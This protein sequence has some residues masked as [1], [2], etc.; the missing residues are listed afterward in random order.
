M[1]VTSK[2][3]S[4]DVDLMVGTLQWN[5]RNLIGRHAQSACKK[6]Q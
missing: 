5:S 4:N 2:T 1:M 3:L 6:Y